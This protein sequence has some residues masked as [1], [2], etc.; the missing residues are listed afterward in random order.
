MGDRLLPIDRE[1][2]LIVKVE[3]TTNPMYGVSPENRPIKDYINNGF[4][5]LDKPAGPTSHEVVAWIKKILHLTKA[6]H[7][8]TLDP[9]VTGV[10]PVLLNKGTKLI[11]TLL[12]A[13]KEYIVLMRLH[14]RVAE[15][16]IKETVSLFKGK[17]FQRPP[18]RSSVKRQLRVRN[19]YY[20]E[21][22]EVVDRDALIVV[23][24]EAGTYARKLVYD[25]GEAIGC[26][27][28]MQELR[29]TRSGPHR[30]DD[31]L[32][33]LHDVL[34]AYRFYEEEGDETGVRAVI[35][36]MENAITHIPKI[37]VRDT[38]VD[39]L[40]HGASL[41]APG[42]LSLD[43]DIHPNDL[44]AF[45]TL[46]GEVI[47]LGRS[48]NTTKQILEMNHGIVATTDSV[49]MGEGTYPALWKP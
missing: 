37:I 17:I 18:V 32:K 33:T 49:V 44:V 23:G 13:G 14:S 29:R 8:G 4:I 9:Q 1:R 5:N 6:G 25:I 16:K 31:T 26:G 15:D 11:Q 42:I 48:L 10:L 21:V 22:L 34:D 12:N 24:C 2:R 20:I 27:A 3:D 38:A 43:S 39:A 30:E 19:I 36:P 46:K 28:H 40:C 35:Q 41:A 7:S 47:G 45:F